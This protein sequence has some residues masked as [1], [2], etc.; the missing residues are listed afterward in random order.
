M[1]DAIAE[2]FVS[3]SSYRGVIGATGNVRAW[4]VSGERGDAVVRAKSSGL[5]IL[6]STANTSKMYDWTHSEMV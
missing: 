6:N 5:S 2:E 1:G 3:R 4:L